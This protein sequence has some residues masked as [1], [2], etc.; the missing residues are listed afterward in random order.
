MF[1]KID[2]M[3]RLR[4]MFVKRTC[5]SVLLFSRVLIINEFFKLVVKHKNDYGTCGLVSFLQ[6][7]FQKPDLLEHSYCNTII[8][9]FRFNS[10]GDFSCHFGW[11]KL[12]RVRRCSYK[13]L[14]SD[15]NSNWFFENW[16]FSSKGWDFVS[17]IYRW[18]FI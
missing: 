8:I 14:K 18:K 12:S 13:R 11:N 4:T 17:T 3:I 2:C 1:L 5:Q 15:S 6:I 7:D 16:P 9:F 10:L